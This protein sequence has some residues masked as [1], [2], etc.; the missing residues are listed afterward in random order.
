MR[1]APVIVASA[2]LCGV[3]VWGQ[4]GAQV[5][6]QAGQP[7]ATKT[8]AA[9]PDIP[10]VIKG[11]TKWEM[12]AAIEGAPNGPIAL[13]DGSGVLVCQ[14]IPTYVGV[15]TSRVLK[16]DQNDEVSVFVDDAGGALGLAFDSK[17][18]L[19][20]NQILP[21]KR[22]KIAIIYPTGQETMLT[23][24]F[25]GKTFNMTNDMVADKKG[26]VYF[27]DPIP[28]GNQLEAGYVGDPPAVYY[29]TPG[30]KTLKIADGI[31][32]PNGVQLSPDEKTLY[33]VDS[34]AEY[35]LAF[36]VQ[37]D[38]TVRNRRN[39]A[40]IE[41][42]PDG[43]P[44]GL[45]SD[46]EGRLYLAARLQPAIQVFSPQGQHLGT[47][48]AHT[49]GNLAFGGPDKRTLYSSGGG[50]LYKI[51]MLAQGPKGRAK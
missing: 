32:R 39:F 7:P 34:F 47:I 42:G 45:A 49:P 38:G 14:F 48:P 9:A 44:D 19:I 43:Q 4:Q 35:L 6:A 5:S 8:V 2:L 16:V 3:A 37:S 28:I 27:T 36:D 18:R 26:G 15:V 1:S 33:V 20:A 22:P 25:E 23:D 40:K 51:Q 29:V 41:G 17:G 50:G 46:S 13:P 31:G 30:G 11:G 12:A 10:G 24:N 21:I